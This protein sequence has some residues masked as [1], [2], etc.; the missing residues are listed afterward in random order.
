MILMIKWKKIM[1][2]LIKNDLL[3]IR[4]NLKSA[5]IM[6]IVLLTFSISKNN[7]FSFFQLLLV[8]YYLYQHLE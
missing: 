3:M 6:I 1:L 4:S 7:N 8:L 2:G 5:T